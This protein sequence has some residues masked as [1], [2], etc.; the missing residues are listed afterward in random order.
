MMSDFIAAASG[1]SMQLRLGWSMSPRLAVSW[2]L[3]ARV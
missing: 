3:V 1:L 2:P